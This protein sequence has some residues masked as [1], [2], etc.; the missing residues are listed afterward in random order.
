LGFQKHLISEP[1]CTRST[2][3]QNEGVTG[4]RLK[5]LS[6]PFEY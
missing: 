5:G 1:L 4:V 2:A 3:T 6:E